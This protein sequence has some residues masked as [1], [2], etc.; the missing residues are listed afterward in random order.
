ML[1]PYHP[2]SFLPPALPPRAGVRRDP[3]VTPLLH[4]PNLPSTHPTPLPL[5][6]QVSDM[7][8]LSQE[9]EQL[10]DEAQQADDDGEVRG[11]GRG[12]EEEKRKGGL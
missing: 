3:P 7:I 12:G 5:P 11:G 8:R 4:P 9:I 10:E 6:V 2:H 1:N